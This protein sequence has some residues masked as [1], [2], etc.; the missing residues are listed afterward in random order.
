MGKLLIL[1]C[2]LRDGGY[3]TN[4]DFTEKKTDTYFR[5]MN[6]LPIEYVE[7]G[8]RSPVYSEYLGKY[9]YCPDF[10]ID[11][12]R[13]LMPDKKIALMLNEKDITAENVDML[14]A[15]CRGKV[16]LIR[17]AVDPNRIKKAITLA[18]IVKSMGFEVA[19]NLMYMSKIAS[20]QSVLSEIKAISGEIDYLN[21]VDSYGG[22]YPDQ[23]A[24]IVKYCKEITSI[25]L[26]YH[27]HNNMEL[28]FA[29]TLAAISSGCEIVDSTV[30]GMGRGAGNLRTELFLTWLSNKSKTSVDF[31]ILADVVSIFEELKHE[32]GWGT[33][34]PYMVSGAN[35]LP[36]KDV[37]DWV[38][39]RYYSINSIIQAL[40]NQK[41]GVKD[42]LKLPLFQPTKNEIRKAVIIGGGPTAIEH[43]E[44]I[45]QF[46]SASESVCIIHASSKNAAPFTNLNVPQYFC[47]VGNEGKRFERAIDGLDLNAFKCILPEYPRKMGTYIPEKSKDYCYELEKVTFTDQFHDSHTALALQIAINLGVEEVYIAGYDGYNS[48]TS[49][50]REQELFMENNDLFA[51]AG[52]FFKTFCSITPTRYKIGT[53]KSIYSLIG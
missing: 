35:S 25:P 34:L 45:R 48:P 53:S 44:A 40:E 26:G 16:D 31:N 19:L 21:L 20:D 22:V 43:S 13:S 7:I 32:F 4:W 17:F 41:T 28:A 46:I 30:T 24:E 50:Q 38:G 29:N 52:T 15:T 9:F 2:T 14:L 42:N 18:G 33:S 51:K 3:Y 47:L 5:A 36:Q 1:D 39:K 27:G 8:Y 49:T 23:V 11:N 6:T 10:V 12:A 37:M